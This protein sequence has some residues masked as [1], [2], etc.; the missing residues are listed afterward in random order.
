M[1]DIAPTPQ[2]DHGRQ[3]Q[4]VFAALRDALAA[5][6]PVEEDARVVVADAG[7]AAAQIAFSPRAQTN[8]HHIL[9]EARRQQRLD[10]LLEI[11]RSAYPD[12]RLLNDACA[13]YERLA[14]QGAEMELQGHL[15][16]PE[17]TPNAPPMMAL[18][19]PADF[20]QRPQ[21]YE[22][23]VHHLLA[24]AGSP[25]AITATLKGAG[26]FGKTTL[27]QALCH[28]PRIH[29]I[30]D[31]CKERRRQRRLCIGQGAPKGRSMAARYEG[32]EARPRGR[33]VDVPAHPCRKR[34][35]LLCRGVTI[36]LSE[37]GFSGF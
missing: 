24:G 28:A 34:R 22:Q 9:V 3:R 32:Q 2:T 4:A 6:Y 29:S 16:S 10:R 31:P 7:L 21:E 33:K 23:L 36:Q 8:W 18:A 19:P 35:A 26:G 14:A 20:V 12:N 5:L 25:V 11:A 1:K 30:R 13:A 37:S 17:R 15:A 27:A